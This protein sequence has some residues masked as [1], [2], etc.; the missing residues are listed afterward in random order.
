MMVILILIFS[1]EYFFFFLFIAIHL[2]RFYWYSFDPINLSEG[3]FAMATTLT[4]SR[5]VF[6]LP[7]I[8]SLGPLYITFG[9]MIS[10]ISQSHHTFNDFIFLIY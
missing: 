7:A 10:V 1:F 2:D 5:L 8:Q 4:F 6:F 3:L 9:R